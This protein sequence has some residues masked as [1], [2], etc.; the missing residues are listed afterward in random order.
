M[1]SIVRFNK[2]T[3]NPISIPKEMRTKITNK[4]WQ[5]KKSQKAGVQHK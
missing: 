2:K 5:L 1:L 4:I 3:G